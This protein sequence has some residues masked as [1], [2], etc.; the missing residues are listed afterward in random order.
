MQRFDKACEIN[1]SSVFTEFKNHA[2]PIILTLEMEAYID[3]ASG[4]FGDTWTHLCKLRGVKANQISKDALN[5]SKYHKACFNVLNMALMNNWKHLMH[6]AFIS[7][8]A[9]F[10]R[11]VGIK[12]ETAFAFFS[13]TLSAF[14][15]TRIMDSITVNDTKGRTEGN[16]LAHKQSRIL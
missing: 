10:A 8:I 16:T 11:G 3:D 15:R 14:S 5:K 9:N 13:N 1:L 6:F 2:K 12:S 4:V 7:S